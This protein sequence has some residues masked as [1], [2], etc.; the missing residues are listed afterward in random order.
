METFLR[1]GSLFLP[2]DLVAE[3]KGGYMSSWEEVIREL[4]YFFELDHSEK[5][6]IDLFNSLQDIAMKKDKTYNL[7]S[8]MRLKIEKYFITDPKKF[9]TC[10]ESLTIKALQTKPE[11]CG[12]MTDT[13]LLCILYLNSQLEKVKWREVHDRYLN[14][15]PEPKTNEF[16]V[17]KLFHKNRY[18]F[19]KML[20]RE[21]GIYP[22]CDMIYVNGNLTDDI[23]AK[24]KLEVAKLRA[25]SRGSKLD[26]KRNLIGQFR[27]SDKITQKLP[28]E[29]PQFFRNSPDFTNPKYSQPQNK[30]NSSRCITS[31]I[32][33]CTHCTRHLGKTVRHIGPYQGR[34]DRCLFDVNGRRKASTC[35]RSEYDGKL[36]NVVGESESMTHDANNGKIEYTDTRDCIYIHSIF[37]RNDKKVQKRPN[38][39]NS[40]LGFGEPRKRAKNKSRYALKLNEEVE[41]IPAIYEVEQVPKTVEERKFE[42]THNILTNE[43]RDK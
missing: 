3:F 13:L 22:G 14:H 33:K 26:Q 2:D 43:S 37:A 15:R 7:L 4:K 25:T 30:I 5:T 8:E 20:D 6:I 19:F 41:M 10:Q 27:A 35:I 21:N 18:E 42:E 24:N 40:H 31:D 28:Q 29:L 36:E 34:G 1:K 11:E 9:L 17:Y 38:N 23:G 16:E 12:P 32:P 39:S